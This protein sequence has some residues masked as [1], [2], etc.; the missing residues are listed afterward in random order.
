MLD[1]EQVLLLVQED[2]RYLDEED[3]N[4]SWSQKRFTWNNRRR[5]QTL[6]LDPL[7][8][9]ILPG[10]IMIGSSPLSTRSLLLQV[11]TPRL[12]QGFQR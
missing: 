3:Q 12:P 9:Q 7:P 10:I 5:R 6:G 2:K 8:Q 11:H 1:E 4:R